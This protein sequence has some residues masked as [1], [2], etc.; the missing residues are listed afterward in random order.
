MLGKI[1]DGRGIGF[2][3]HHHVLGVKLPNTFLRTL[4]RTG[5]DARCVY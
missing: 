3:G 1:Q 4:M 2:K 5:Q